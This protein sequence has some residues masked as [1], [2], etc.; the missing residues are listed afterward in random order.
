LAWRSFR[1]LDGDAK[2]KR[3]AMT[4]TISMKLST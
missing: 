2:P 3:Y 4:G 1:Y